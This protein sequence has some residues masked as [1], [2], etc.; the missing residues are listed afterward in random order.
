MF[1]VEHRESI[2]R[3]ELQWFEFSDLASSDF[4]KQ[5]FDKK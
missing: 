2:P 5:R 4:V 3:E 1:Q